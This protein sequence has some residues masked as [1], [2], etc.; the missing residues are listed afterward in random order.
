M[1]RVGMGWL[2]M[3][4]RAIYENG[5]LRLL[6][7]VDLQEGQEVTINIEAVSETNDDPLDRVLGAFDDEITDLSTT[8]SQTL[9]ARFGKHDDHTG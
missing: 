1:K 6:D 5:Q 7:K 2:A 4:V 9:K 3:V 8:V